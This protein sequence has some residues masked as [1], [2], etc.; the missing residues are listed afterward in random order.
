MNS[1]GNRYQFQYGTLIET[2]ANAP[3]IVIRI[4]RCRYE[5]TRNDATIAASSA[6]STSLPNCVPSIFMKFALMS[7][8]VGW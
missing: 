8:P 2:Q 4:T 7:S 5:P 3:I 1:N 6:P